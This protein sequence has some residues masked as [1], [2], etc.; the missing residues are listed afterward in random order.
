MKKKAV[1]KCTSLWSN[2]K[3]QNFILKGYTKSNVTVKLDIYDW[4]I[5]NPMVVQS[6][7]ETDH[8]K[9]YIYGYTEK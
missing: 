7:I 4:F 3:N 2:I 1:G 9:V 6:P 5:Q 8:L